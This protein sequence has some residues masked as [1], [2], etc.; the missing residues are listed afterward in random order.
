MFLAKKYSNVHVVY[1][2]INYVV[3]LIEIEI[4][5]KISLEKDADTSFFVCN[6]ILLLNS[7]LTYYY[8]LQ[9]TVSYSIT[10]ETFYKT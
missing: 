7:F 6:V 8:P 10:M 9:T 3:I 4:N 5:Y 2:Q 1:R